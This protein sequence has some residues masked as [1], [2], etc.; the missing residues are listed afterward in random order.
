[1]D[2]RQKLVVGLAKGQSRWP[3]MTKR[4]CAWNPPMA[5]NAAFLRKSFRHYRR[6]RSSVVE[7][8]LGKGEVVSSILPGSTIIINDLVRR[9]SDRA[10]VS[11]MKR[12]DPYVGSKGFAY[13]NLARPGIGTVTRP[14]I[15]EVHEILRKHRALVVHFSSVPR[16]DNTEHHFP[17]DLRYA[18]NNPNMRGGLCCSVV[19]PGDTRENAFGT[20]GLILDLNTNESLIA[21]SRGDGGATLNQGVRDFDPKY[22]YFDVASVESTLPTGL[23]AFTMNGELRITLSGDYSYCRVTARSSAVK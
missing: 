5:R 7:H 6:C 15:Q 11:P 3:D 12:G 23:A 14:S 17:D 19:R 20:V 22:K 4:A 8:S 18:L 10:H 13:D 9:R 2:A 21:V 16:L 1:V